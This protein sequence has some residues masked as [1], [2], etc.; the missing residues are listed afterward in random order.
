[1]VAVAMVDQ[2]TQY[3]AEARQLGELAFDL[4]VQAAAEI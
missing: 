2:V 3:L 4:L 1:M